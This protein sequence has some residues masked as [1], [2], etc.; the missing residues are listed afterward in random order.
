MI[1]EAIIEGSPIVKKN[2]Q[3]V[4]FRHGRPMKYNTPQ[5]KRWEATAIN[6]LWG[7]DRPAEPIGQEC[8]LVCT[9]FMQTR[10]T[11]DLSAL[12]EGI[13]DV[14]VKVGVLLDD[15]SRVVIGHDG[16]RVFHDPKRPRMEIKILSATK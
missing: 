8:L 10:R 11:V 5:Y 7:H 12:Y 1:F 2:N 3:K 14:L 4:A 9:F 16:S 6:Q 13:Q 15:N